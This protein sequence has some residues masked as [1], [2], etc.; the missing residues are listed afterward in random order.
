LPNARE[1]VSRIAV[2][3]LAA[4]AAVC[5]WLLPV[6]GSSEPLP[7]NPR[8]VVTVRGHT[9]A[10]EQMEAVEIAMGVKNYLLTRGVEWIDLRDGADRAMPDIF[11]DILGATPLAVPTPTSGSDINFASLGAVMKYEEKSIA[12]DASPGGATAI[13]I[14][15]RD[16]I[17]FPDLWGAR[18]AYRVHFMIHQVPLP[19]DP[20][21]GRLVRGTIFVTWES[22]DHGIDVDWT[23]WWTDETG[24]WNRHHVAMP[25]V[26]RQT[27]RW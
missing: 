4:A 24:Y 16:V 9:Y 1:H 17:T 22:K 3:L 13:N 6:T 10:R 2:R 15:G 8:Y 27:K 14:F 12:A 26:I 11:Q 25:V 7:D 5:A 19:F 21:G 23:N 18:A 20:P